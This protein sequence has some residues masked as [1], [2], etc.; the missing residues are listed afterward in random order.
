MILIITVIKYD[1]F[2]HLLQIVLIPNLIKLGQQHADIQG[3]Q[4]DYF[5]VFRKAMNEVFS[6]YLGRAYTSETRTAW[7]KIF[8][9]ITD[10]VEE[11]YLEGQ[12]IKTRRESQQL[13]AKADHDLPKMT[14][15][16]C[17]LSENRISKSTVDQEYSDLFQLSEQDCAP[18]NEHNP[19]MDAQKR[20]CPVKHVTST[21][22]STIKE[23]STCNGDEQPPGGV[24]DTKL[25]NLHI[26]NNGVVDG[27]S[28]GI[29]SSNEEARGFSDL[30]NCL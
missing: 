22:G 15:K 6:K 10:K 17:P 27:L 26:N 28:T 3:F 7:N 29:Q 16:M 23:R 9:L 21:D 11:G 12:E 24:E 19:D 13:Q 18:S 30:G 2:R 8:S 25:A 20:G 14:S 1:T 5:D 4:H